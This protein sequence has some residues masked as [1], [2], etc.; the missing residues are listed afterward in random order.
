MDEELEW[1]D[2]PDEHEFW[3]RNKEAAQRGASIE[4]IFVFAPGRLAEAR[5]NPAIYG[6]REGSETGVIGKV[7]DRERLEKRAPEAVASAG[8]GFILI[9]DEQAIVDVFSPDGFARG[10]V[11]FNSAEV[12]NYIRLFEKFE[13]VAHPLRF[14]PPALEAGGED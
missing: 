13:A 5:E 9:D 6:H 14:E 3:R 11:T 10:Y 2:T 7:V 12:S 1:T 4:R 8:Q